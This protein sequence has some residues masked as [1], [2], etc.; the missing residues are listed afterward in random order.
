MNNWITYF[1]AYRSNRL[2]YDRLKKQG[3][4]K[5][6]DLEG[7]NALEKLEEELLTAEKNLERYIGETDSPREA[8]RR[9]D[10]K[11]FLSYRYIYGLSMTETA[12]AMSVSRDTLYRIRRR[13]LSKSFPFA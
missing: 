6:H 7:S 4:S 2:L 5:A 10:E 8:A 11:L 3:A 12:R 13:V 1:E 9:A